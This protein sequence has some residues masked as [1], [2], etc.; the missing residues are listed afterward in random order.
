MAELVPRVLG[1]D[2]PMAFLSGPT[3]AKELMDASPSGAVMASTDQAVADSCATLFH[4]AALRVYTTTDVVGV[5]IGGALKNVYAVA[6]GAVEGMGLGTNPTA[7][8]VTRACAEM[9]VMAVALGARAHTMAG[10][11]GIGDLMLTCMGGAS[12]NK[13]VG[14][15]IGRGESL[16]AILESRQRSLE[17]VAE[18]VATAPAAEK[19]ARR[20]GVDAPL[21]Q[22]VAAV[23]D[24]R[25]EVREAILALMQKPRHTDFSAMP[26][27]AEEQRRQRSLSGPLG[28]PARAWAG[29]ALAQGCLLLALAARSLSTRSRR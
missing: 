26:H 2:Q 15:R 13:A 22:A 21:A 14:Q 4:S 9:N 1:R 16:A 23:L 8:L 24:G 28:L 12:R 25:L 19:L 20:L 3:F 17:G 27:I 29:L 18:G 11:S 10:L 6:A 5:E 7:F